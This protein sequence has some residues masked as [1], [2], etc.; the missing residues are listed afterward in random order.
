VSQPESRFRRDT[1][2]EPLAEGE[3]AARIDPGWWISQGPNGGYLAAIVLRALTHAVADPERAPRSL[4]V[5][6]TSPPARGEARISARV[7]RRGRTLS[8]VSARLSQGP[9]LRALALAAFALPRA[10]PELRRAFMPEVPPPEDCPAIERRVP[11]HD[12]LEVRWAI[13]PLPFSGAG[14]GEALCGGWIRTRDAT[15]VDPVLLAAYADGF[16]PAIFG[17]LAPGSLAGGVPTIDLSVH[18]RAAARPGDEWILGVFRSRL[19][20]EGF[21]EEDGELWSRDGT[22]LAQSRQLA[23]V[24]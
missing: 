12:H 17:A 4:T 14:A 20:H 13:G 3:Y 19:A 1:H 15:P 9:K 8:S 2:V 5:H 11:I 24:R 16:P 6:Y 10:G 23:A 21:V 18:F 22:L 7:E